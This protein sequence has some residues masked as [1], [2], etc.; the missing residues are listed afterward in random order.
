[1]KILYGNLV[2]CQLVIEVAFQC[3]CYFFHQSLQGLEPSYRSRYKMPSY[4][5]LYGVQYGIILIYSLIIVAEHRC[6]HQRTG[7]CAYHRIPRS[8]DSL[9]FLDQSS[10]PARHSLPLRP[11]PLP[12]RAPQELPQRGRFLSSLRPNLQADRRTALQAMPSPSFHHR[13][14]L[15]PPPLP[16]LRLHRRFLA[17]EQL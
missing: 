10:R 5:S 1:M 15:A 9:S 17:P 8:R 12:P 16:R 7:R 6:S 2:L 14:A 3:I 13:R 4:R 11:P